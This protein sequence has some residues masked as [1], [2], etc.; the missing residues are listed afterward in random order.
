[1]DSTPTTAAGQP[2]RKITRGQVRPLTL[3]ILKEQGG[4]CCF[5]AKPI[6]L[7]E[8]DGAILEHCHESGRV[9]GVA[10]RSCNKMEGVVYSA[11]GRWCVGKMDY[12]LVIPA[13]RRLA[14]YLEK[15]HYPYIY[16]SHLTDEE[17]KLKAAA[18]ARKA[19]ATRKAAQEIKK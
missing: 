18:K 1:M 14:D 11:V 3:K 17:K 8:K 12:D 16:Y 4:L 13:L 5:C 6:D 7:K 15:E 2:L 9:R 19:R 10:H